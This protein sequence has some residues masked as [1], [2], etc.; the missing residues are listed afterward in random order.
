[1]LTTGC[2]PKEAAY[3]V[4]HKSIRKSTYMVKHQVHTYEAFV[5]A[6]YTKTKHDYLWLLP[7]DFDNVVKWIMSMNDAGFTSAEK[8][9]SSLES[10]YTTQVLMKAGD[11]PKRHNDKK[12]YCMR[13]ARAYHATEWVKL[14]HEYR[15]MEWKPEPLNPLQ[16]ETEKMTME[17]YATKGI[18]S[19]WSVQQRCVDKYYGDP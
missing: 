19:K 7:K 16:H 3:I 6:D 1:M 13:T 18:V 9:R 5:P 4:W 12:W 11:V 10:F 17:H 14:V 8:L 2:R 15:Y